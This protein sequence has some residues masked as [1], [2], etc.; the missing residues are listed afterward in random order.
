[1]FG[2][3]TVNAVIISST[4]IMCSTPQHG[5]SEE[6]LVE[7]SVNA[8]DFTQ[9]QTLFMYEPVPTIVSFYPTQIAAHGSSVVTVLGSGF[10]SGSTS[11]PVCRFGSQV[12]VP[13]RQVSQETVECPIAAEQLAGN[14]TVS[15][16]L[17]GEDFYPVLAAD[18]CI[19]V[20]ADSVYES[21]S[22]SFGFVLTPSVVTIVGKGF[23]PSSKVLCCFDTSRA[24]ASVSTFLTSTMRTCAI[25]PQS[26]PTVLQLMLSATE[27][28]ASPTESM[29]GLDF[30]VVHPPTLVGLKPSFGVSRGG[31]I[32]TVAGQHFLMP[33]GNAIDCVFGGSQRVEATVVSHE[34]VLCVAPAHGEGQVSLALDARGSVSAES[35]SLTFVYDSPLVVT[36][37]RPSWG[38]PEEPV[39]ITISGESFPAARGLV[40]VFGG[41]HIRPSTHISTTE[42]TCKVPTDL[43]GNS[44]VEV[45]FEGGTSEPALV[46]MF[47]TREPVSYTHLR[48]HET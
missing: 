38:V 45:G 27:S 12:T 31:S 39:T 6:V 46:G 33:S 34:E 1:M 11:G 18:L 15:I 21:I 20:L 44:T 47:Q 43:V 9:T 41:M 5:I 16:S 10:R 7:M 13:G 36:S 22:P 19:S 35:T 25:P 37:L 4:Q 24:A 30:A 28:C 26:T 2:T 42:L 3:K 17:N 8:H 23:E 48:A 29:L 40:C 14:V 32:V